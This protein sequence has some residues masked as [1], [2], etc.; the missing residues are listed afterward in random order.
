MIVLK[1]LPTLTCALLLNFKHSRTQ[2]QNCVKY[3]LLFST[4]GDAALVWPQ[5]FIFGMISFAVGHFY[6]II[7]IKSSSRSFLGDSPTYSVVLGCVLYGSSLLIFNN[8]LRPGLSDPVLLFGIPFYIL[9]LTTT[10]G[11]EKLKISF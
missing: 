8:F 9:W 7:S 6:Y 5:G 1:C 3:G 10:V 4:L 2:R 11:R